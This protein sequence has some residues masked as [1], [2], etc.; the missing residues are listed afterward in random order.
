M[1]ADPFSWSHP[2]FFGGFL[3]FMLVL[4]VWGRRAKRRSPAP[5]APVTGA[6][7]VLGAIGQLDANIEVG[8]LLT[9]GE[10]AH[11]SGIR[12]GLAGRPRAPTV[13]VGEAGGRELLGIRTLEMRP[14]GIAG[15]IAAAAEAEGVALAVD[16]ARSKDAVGMTIY[17][18]LDVGAVELSRSIAGGL[19]EYASARIRHKR[20]PFASEDPIDQ[21]AIVSRILA[22]ALEQQSGENE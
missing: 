16:L 12:F 17:D 22:R 11:Q 1:A 15:R 3:A 20:T 9:R 14:Q 4:I 13:V 19:L 8:V 5:L 10:D 2:Y 18:D 6:A 7:A 21:I